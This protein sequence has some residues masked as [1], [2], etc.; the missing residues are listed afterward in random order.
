MNDC[1]ICLDSILLKIQSVIQKRPRILSTSNKI[2]EAGA[3]K[4]ERVRFENLI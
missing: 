3:S 2:E 1:G 4:F